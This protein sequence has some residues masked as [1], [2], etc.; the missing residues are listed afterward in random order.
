MRLS[1]SSAKDA[2]CRN[3]RG[4][5][6]ASCGAI[7]GASL[8]RQRVFNLGLSA[9]SVERVGWALTASATSLEFTGLP[10]LITPGVRWVMASDAHRESINCV[11]NTIDLPQQRQSHKYSPSAVLTALQ[12]RRGTHRGGGCRGARSTCL[13][14]I[15]VRGVREFRGRRLWESGILGN[16]SNGFAPYGENRLT[17]RVQQQPIYEP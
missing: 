4:R 13:R 9:A 8:R 7:P 17:D 1:A 12:R 15:Q 5:V 3:G 16:S 2:F 11:K 6:V 10:R 14:R